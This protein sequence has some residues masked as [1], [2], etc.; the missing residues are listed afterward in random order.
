MRWKYP[1][2][3]KRALVGPASAVTSQSDCQCE[4]Y[5]RSDVIESGGGH[6]VLADGGGEE[7]ELGE[8][9]GEHREGGDGEGNAHEEQELAVPDL[10]GAVNRASEDEGDTDPADE[11]KGDA[12]SCD[13]E[14]PASAPAD[15]GEVKLETHKEEEEEEAD[16][17]DGLQDR[18]AP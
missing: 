4:Q 15:G 17:G 3:Y 10:V 18:S 2:G 16:A 12:G 6:G 14:G 13:P 1:E 5:P 7:P 8:D 9:A 11:R